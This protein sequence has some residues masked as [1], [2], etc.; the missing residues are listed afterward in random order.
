MSRYFL[1]SLYELLS[2]FVKCMRVPSGVLSP[3]DVDR[4]G[5]NDLSECSAQSESYIYSIG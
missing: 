2:K 5:P 3:S 1:I 4:Y